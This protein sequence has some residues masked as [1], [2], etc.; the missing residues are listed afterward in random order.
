MPSI[1]KPKLCQLLDLKIKINELY[2]ICSVQIIQYS[3]DTSHRKDIVQFCLTTAKRPAMDRNS[4]L[5]SLSRILK[6]GTVISAFSLG[7]R[8]QRSMESF[9]NDLNSLTISRTLSAETLGAYSSNSNIN[10]SSTNLFSHFIVT[11]RTPW[12]SS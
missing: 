1:A 9:F 10:D 2:Y 12:E 5:G 6:R 11:L 8:P 7:R 4:R 3:G